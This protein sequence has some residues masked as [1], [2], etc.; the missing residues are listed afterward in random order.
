M[1]AQIRVEQA[2]P[3]ATAMTRA[4]RLDLDSGAVF[5]LCL[6]A[7]HLASTAAGILR[8]E[9]LS[10]QETYRR[11]AFLERRGYLRNRACEEDRRVHQ[12]FLTPR[13]RE[14]VNRLLGPFQ[15]TPGVR[16]SGRPSRP[17]PSPEPGC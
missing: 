9:V 16:P 7:G 10:R 3:M 8:L 12:L 13:G 11:I 2:A 14:A 15:E 1:K 6:V 17:A 5:V 4:Y